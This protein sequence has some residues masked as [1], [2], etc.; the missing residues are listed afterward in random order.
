[1]SKSEI[2]VLA[3]LSAAVVL[4]AG[5][6]IL[7]NKNAE[8]NE[9]PQ[10]LFG[11]VSKVNRIDFANSNGYVHL[12]KSEGRWML[13]DDNDFDVNQNSADML[14]KALSTVKISNKLV[15]EKQS[16]LNDYSLLSPQCVIEFGDEDGNVHT[17]RIGTASSM[18]EEIYIM[19][20]ENPNVVY[21]ASP[22]V[23][24]AFS[25]AKL[26]LLAYPSIP[27]P[28][29]GQNEVRIENYYGSFRLFKEEDE[30]YLDG[31][32]PVSVSEETAYNYYYLTWD[33]HWRGSVEYNAEDI[34]KYDLSKP[35]ISYSLRYNE[36]T[37]EKE[38]NLELGSSLP[39]GTCYAKLKDDNNIFLLDSMMADWLEST[40][41]ESFYELQE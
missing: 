34:S 21:V 32:T 39:D 3:I 7:Q 28:P 4:L 1:M 38:F 9:A 2:K 37:D 33:M 16:Q 10:Y 29:E 30:W 35:R 17:V 13:K 24:Q 6:L 27:K 5:V 22:E 8:K 20:D 25:C 18:T 41:E 15:I 40:K 19:A 14:V 12:I 36:G 11:D 31:D 23:A 26:D